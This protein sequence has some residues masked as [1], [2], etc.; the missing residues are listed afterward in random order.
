MEVLRHGKK[1]KEIECPECNALLA[2]NQTDV[3][4]KYFLDESRNQ[5]FSDAVIC[6]ECGTQIIII[7][8]KK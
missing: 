2:Y 7:K 1:Y 8:V 3:V 6:P 5:Y 4:Q